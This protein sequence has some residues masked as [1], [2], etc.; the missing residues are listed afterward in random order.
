MKLA[1]GN[2][3]MP[4]TPYQTMIQQ[5]AG[6]GYDGLEVCVGAKWP[7][8]AQNL[9][10]A[11]R[12]SFRKAMDAAGLGI[13]SLMMSGVTV[14]ELDSASHAAN[15]EA[16]RTVFGLSADLGFTE[17][18]VVNTM[19]GKIAEWETQRSLLAERVA[20]WARVAAECGGVFACEGHVGGIINSS[21]REL[22]LL[23][24]V[25]LPGLKVNFDYSHFELIDEPL[26]EAMDR[27]VPYA[28]G[29]HVKD[30]IGRPP[31]FKFL[32]PG[33]GQVDYAD[34]MRRIY[35]TGYNSF[36]TVEISGMIFN[37][38]GY[39]AIKAAEFC[40]RTLSTAR[41]ASGVPVG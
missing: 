6:M 2:Y 3:G 30:S 15:L 34:Y 20:D 24:Q 4:N 38:P 12:K 19:G 25:N 37:A 35:R 33:E 26:Q 40:Y 11:E 13:A 28:V 41:A 22:W 27:L 29:T 7:T 21:G 32:L 1:Y 36:I 5:V 31:S 23:R 17:N 9:R 14:Y 39:D 16:L 18:I 8:S 10:G